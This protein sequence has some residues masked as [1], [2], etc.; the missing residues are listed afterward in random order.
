MDM[1]SA[2]RI[3][4]LIEKDWINMEKYYADMERECATQ[5]E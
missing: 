2:T 1:M 5:Q 4:T 3:N